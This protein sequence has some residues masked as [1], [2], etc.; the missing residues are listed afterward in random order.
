VLL[1]VHAET[2]EVHAALSAIIESYKWPFQQE[3]VFWETAQ[4]CAAF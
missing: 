1:L 4:V 3:S 2:P